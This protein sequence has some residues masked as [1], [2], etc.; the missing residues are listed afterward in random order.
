MKRHIP[1]FGL[2]I[3][4]GTLPNIAQSGALLDFLATQDRH[5]ESRAHFFAADELVPQSAFVT[6]Y[7]EHEKFDGT[8]YLQVFW[9]IGSKDLDALVVPTFGRFI[10]DETGRQIDDPKAL[11]ESPLNFYSNDDELEQAVI[12]GDSNVLFDVVVS[13]RHAGEGYYKEPRPIGN[14]SEQIQTT[15]DDHGEPVLTDLSNHEVI[16]EEKLEQRMAR[17]DAKWAR[18]WDSEAKHALKDLNKLLKKNIY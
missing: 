7:S 8:K 3:M 12:Q 2:L 10:V 14:G 9:Q 4:G 1:M 16:S 18:Y 15:L 11:D 17:R 13:L 5:D 6:D